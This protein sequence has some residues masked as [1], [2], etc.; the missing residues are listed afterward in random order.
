[1]ETPSQ[2]RKIEEH[3]AGEVAIVV[4]SASGR[5]LHASTRPQGRPPP[6]PPHTHRDTA[7]TRA[8]GRRAGRRRACSWRGSGRPAVRP[9]SS[10]HHEAA[11]TLVASAAASPRIRLQP[12]HTMPLRAADCVPLL[13][14]VQIKFWWFERF[15]RIQVNPRTPAARGTAARPPAPGLEPRLQQAARI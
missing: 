4:A 8:R 10:L 9:S 3:R 13:Q 12:H 1:M 6:S 2:R 15:V 11:S 5:F 7:S 14:P